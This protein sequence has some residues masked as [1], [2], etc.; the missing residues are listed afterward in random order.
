MDNKQIACKGYYIIGQ[1]WTK[2]DLACL[3]KLR[4]DLSTWKQYMLYINGDETESVRADYY[5]AVRKAFGALY[6]A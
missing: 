6:D 3:Y 5:M 4:P 2:Y 1:K